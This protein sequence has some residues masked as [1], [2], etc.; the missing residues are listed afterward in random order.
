[1]RVAFWPLMALLA[2]AGC[3]PQAPSPR[4]PPIHRP[5]TPNAA[6]LVTLPC[7]GNGPLR[8]VSDE[9]CA[10]QINYV[11]PVARRALLRIAERFA[12]SHRGYVVRYMRASWPS[13]VR[14]MPP[15]LSHGDG[16]EVDLALFYTDARGRPRP[17]PPA[18][19]G[20][21]SYEP[22][23]READRVCVGQHGD[24]DQP[25]PPANRDWRLNERPTADLMRLLSAD[26]TVSH[27]FIEPHLKAR[28]GFARD[29][30]VR[31]A[32]CQAA[33]HDDHLHVDFR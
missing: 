11:T 33:R 5:A 23:R 10:S 7:S 9:Y 2:L 14:P 4:R 27:M 17:F 12:R 28:L 32:G 26:P 21:R 15:T 20:Y 8:P 16:R 19:D 29:P 22:P 6:G 1:M 13:G 24:H 31:F 18:S 30:K 25:D 3:G